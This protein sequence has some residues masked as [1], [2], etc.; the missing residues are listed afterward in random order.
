[1]NLEFPEFIHLA[2]QLVGILN[3]LD[4]SLLK[5]LK[6]LKPKNSIFLN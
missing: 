1:M 4:F 6:K 5:N 2:L 3:I